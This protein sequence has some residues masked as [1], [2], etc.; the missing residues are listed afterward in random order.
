MLTTGRLRSAAGSTGYPEA[1]RLNKLLAQLQQLRGVGGHLLLLPPCHLLVQRLRDVGDEQ[2]VPHLVDAHLL[3]VLLRQIEDHIPLYPV[4]DEE[5]HV[6]LEPHRLEHLAHVLHRPARRVERDAHLAQRRHG[7]RGELHANRARPRDDV[8]VQLREHLDEVEA[9]ADEREAELL[10]VLLRQQKDR[11]SVHV[12]R[13]EVGRHLAEA[14]RVEPRGELLAVPREHV[15]AEVQL[16]QVGQAADR[17]EVLRD[18]LAV[19]VVLVEVLVAP[20]DEAAVDLEAGDALAG[21]ALLVVRLLQP[22]ELHPH[23]A[24]PHPGALQLEV[25]RVDVAELLAALLHLQPRHV[26]LHRTLE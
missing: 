15:A 20:L 25:V 23:V 13:E 3:E 19:E 6:L 9:V 8:V 18:G 16:L 5:L 1:V 21:G 26:H 22:A 24:L 12:V 17:R 11:P 7:V 14:Q 4:L 2:T 10:E